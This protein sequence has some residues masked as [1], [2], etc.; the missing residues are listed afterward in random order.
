MNDPGHRGDGHVD[1][2]LG[3]LLL[4]ELAPAM[5]ARVLHHLAVC[6]T[7]AAAWA[8]L[9]RADDVLAAA[10]PAR[11]APST[12]RQGLVERAQTDARRRR[13]TARLRPLL[14][15]LVGAAAGSAAVWLALAPSSPTGGSVPVAGRRVA[16]L[17]GA[18]DRGGG[19]YVDASLRRATLRVWHLPTLAPGRVYEVWWVTPAR[20]LVGGSFGVDRAGDAT[21]TLALPAGWRQARAIGVTVE[22]VPGTLR[23]TTPR[24]VGG[25]LA[26]L[27]DPPPTRRHAG[28]G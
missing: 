14:S 23:P 22:P 5:A 15:A 12:L 4:G 17:A 20:H 10:A 21:L 9:E 26:T 19:V 1:G 24:V 8:E 18:G 11:Q 3:D 25:T 13:Q 28:G 27:A 6:P 2:R 7:C 16:V